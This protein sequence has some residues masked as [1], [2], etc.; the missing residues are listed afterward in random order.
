[1]PSPVVSAS[2]HCRSN[3]ETEAWLRPLLPRVPITRVTD[4]TPID[5]TGI[6]VWSATTP[7]AQDL[8]VHAGKGTT[9]VAA[10]ISA[11]MEAIERVSAENIAAGRIA[12]C[13]F[14]QLDQ[15]VSNGAVLDPLLCDLPFETSY[16][17]YQTISWVLGYDLLAESDVW[18]ATDLIVS[19]AR[20]GVCKGVETNGLASGNSIT[21][22]I[23]HALYEVIERD[24]VAAETI[25]YM[26]GEST[27]GRGAPLR[28][29]DPSTAPAVARLLIDRLTGRGLSV[30]L[31]GLTNDLDIP[32][33]GALA[34]DSD[35][36]GADGAPVS[37]EGYGA[38]LDPVRA[39]VRAL[40]EAAQ[41]RAIVM[42]GARD[43]F[44]GAEPLPDRTEMLLRRAALLYGPAR[45]PFP[46]CDE[47]PKDLREQL[48]V[49]LDRLRACGLTQVAVIDL[50]RVD[51]GVPVVRV[52]VPG[53]SHPYGTSSRR[54]GHRVLARLL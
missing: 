51:L 31:L 15:D 29:L 24:A 34:I 32:V 9:P 19:P 46:V 11:I 16:T 12:R 33:I 27:D 23:L 21:E 30:R 42:L 17:K 14:D 28:L 45:I 43:T 10:R 1:M 26:H 36:P 41:A 44:E 52:I 50:T 47:A 38:D 7:L 54:P 35:F 40:T 39:L 37:F 18:V 49:V 48:H 6:P 22:A 53:L 4:V 2:G 25:T 3:E 20:E 8:T 5:D 13:S